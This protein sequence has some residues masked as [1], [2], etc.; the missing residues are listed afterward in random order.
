MA[1]LPGYGR[2]RI[3]QETS[4][5]NPQ[6]AKKPLLLSF[7]TTV[8]E[9]SV[10]TDMYKTT[11]TSIPKL[12][13][14]HHYGPKSVGLFQYGWNHRHLKDVWGLCSVMWWNKTG[15][16]CTNCICGGGRMKHTLTITPQLLWGMAVAQCSGAALF[17]FQSHIRKPW[18]QC[19]HWDSSKGYFTVTVTSYSGCTDVL[20]VIF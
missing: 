5:E 7:V 18:F 3:P 15:T 17:L 9:A 12:Q 14:L 6:L 4:N 20:L 8:I 13:D 16:F 2:K 10:F 11:Q 19:F 1:T